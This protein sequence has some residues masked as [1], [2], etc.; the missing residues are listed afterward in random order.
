MTSRDWTE[1]LSRLAPDIPLGFML[2]WIEWESGGN[3]CGVGM[4]GTGYW[5]EAGI[6]QIDFD[7]TNSAY[8]TNSNVVRMESAGVCNLADAIQHKALTQAQADAHAAVNIKLFRTC[9][10]YAKAAVPEWSGPDFYAVAK[11]AHGYPGLPACFGRANAA[12]NTTFAAA[13]AAIPG[14]ASLAGQ[15]VAYTNLRDYKDSAGGSH[16]GIF[17]GAYAVGQGLDR[18]G[19]SMTSTAAIGKETIATSRAS[20]LA[21][22]ETIKVAGSK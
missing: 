19:T 18:S 13:M 4:K 3:P 1:T 11:T 6:A 10:A 22:K 17:D 9:I 15:F 16:K 7:T 2:A 14:N 20:L 8:G 21:S 12:G 5:R